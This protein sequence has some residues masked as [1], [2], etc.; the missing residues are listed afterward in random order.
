MRFALMLAFAGLTVLILAVATPANAITC[1]S[2]CS[3]YNDV[4]GCY[5]DCLER[6]YPDVPDPVKKPKARRV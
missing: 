2:W 4:P 1:S 3:K 5:S 6:G